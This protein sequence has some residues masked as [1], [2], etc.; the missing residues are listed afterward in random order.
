MPKIL[1]TTDTSAVALASSLAC[2]AS[3]AG[4]TV[5]SVEVKF[6]TAPTTS[7]DLTLTLN[8]IA[9]ATYDTVLRSVDPSV[10][11]A[12]SV[13][14]E[15]PFYLYNEDSLDVAYTNTDTRTI[16]VTYKWREGAE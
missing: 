6:S 12:T 13:A 9:G 15:G 8:S 7:E 14:W 11:S 2:H 4:V 10:A 16:G 3:G 5:L 1:R